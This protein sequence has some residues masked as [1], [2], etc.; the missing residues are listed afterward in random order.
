L[1][2]AGRDALI[3]TRRDA[4][5]RDRA[6]MELSTTRFA[7]ALAAPL[8]AAFALVA[9]ALLKNRNGVAP[10]LAIPVRLTS[11]TSQGGALKRTFRS[12]DYAYIIFQP[13]TTA[14]PRT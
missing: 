13:P 3:E 8:A 4:F 11:A 6:A 5:P 7:H 9:A 12:M 14:A 2:A 1:P 10:Y